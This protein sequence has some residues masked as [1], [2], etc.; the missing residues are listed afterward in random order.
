MN[1]FYLVVIVIISGLLFSLLSSED[2]DTGSDHERFEQYIIGIKYLESAK[3]L[4]TEEKIEYYKKLV[5][6]TDFSAEKAK[7]YIN[8]YKDNPE[9][10]EKKVNSVINFLESSNQS[11]KE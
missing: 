10:W 4:S 3:E 6:I 9:K 1:K 11:D 5:E 7:D 2:K 8:Q